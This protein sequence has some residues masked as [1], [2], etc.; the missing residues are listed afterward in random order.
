[1]ISPLSSR[2]GAGPS[3]SRFLLGVPWARRRITRSPE[4][5]P[6]GY[7]RR[8]AFTLARNPFWD[9][10]AG[11]R[12]LS[13]TSSCFR[14]A[15][16]GI[17]RDIPSIDRCHFL[18]QYLLL[19]RNKIRKPWA[20]L[21]RRFTMAWAHCPPTAPVEGA[22]RCQW[23]SL[24]HASRLSRGA[25][26]LALKPRLFHPSAVHMD[27][28]VATK[29]SSL[30]GRFPSQTHTTNDLLAS[31]GFDSKSCAQPP[32]TQQPHPCNSGPSASHR[33]SGRPA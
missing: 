14:G 3:A 16:T 5:G 12:R 20:V 23:R 1:M 11:A 22:S 6:A 28:H 25:C 8:G 13:T 15:F 33:L 27:R 32:R 24:W 10:C 4:A 29:C 19:F 2:G 21:A 31:E 18:G 26:H 9:C 30:L 7:R 17:H